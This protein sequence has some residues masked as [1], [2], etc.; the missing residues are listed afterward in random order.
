MANT[1]RIVTNPP[2][3]RASSLHVREGGADHGG[4]DWDAFERALNAPPGP[5]ARGP[6]TAMDGA[7]R[8]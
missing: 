1:S 3:P 5:S 6:V 2:L 7:A 4:F 8:Q